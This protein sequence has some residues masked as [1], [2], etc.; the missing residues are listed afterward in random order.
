M[1]PAKAV[2]FAL[3]LLCGPATAQSLT[4]AREWLPAGSLAL[5]ALL[6]QPREALDGGEKQS[7]LVEFGRLAFRSPEVLGGTARKAGLSCQACHAGGHVNAHFFIPELSDKP[8]AIDV[9]HALWNARSEDGRF[10]P[11]E[12]PSLRGVAQKPRLGFDKRSGSL[13]EFTRNVMVLEFAAAEPSALVLDALVAYQQAL[14]PGAHGMEAVT[15]RRDLAD[16]ARHLRVLALPLA[17]EDAEASD[18]AA[19]MIRG[20]IGFIH[21]R[22]DGEA[23]RGQQQILEQWSR[24]LAAIAGLARNGQWPAARQRRD[25]LAS[26]II[27]PAPG[28]ITAE[29]LSLYDPERLKAWLSRPV[30]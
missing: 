20:Q 1:R 17:E 24:E 26:A 29:K 18:L 5:P 13:R 16:L 19:A 7:F 2:L 22:F 10:N 28:L 30:P 9:T 12:I 4:G 15:L 14:L 25:A 11:R 6:E 27:T 8:G 3:A 23:L 21:E